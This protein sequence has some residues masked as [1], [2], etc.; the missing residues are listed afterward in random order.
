MRGR[1][2]WAIGGAHRTSSRS[3]ESPTEPR[4]NCDIADDD[5]LPTQRDK[6]NAPARSSSSPKHSPTSDQPMSPIPP[7]PTSSPPTEKPVDASRRPPLFDRVSGRASPQRSGT[8]PFPMEID[9]VEEM[10]PDGT[11]FVFVES[12]HSKARAMRAL[13]KEQ[14]SREQA[15]YWRTTTQPVN[16]VKTLFT[17]PI[18]PVLPDFDDI[19][20]PMR[21]SPV[22]GSVDEPIGGGVGVRRKT[23]VVKKLRDR[24]VK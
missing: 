19:V 15:E 16:R 6:P 3:A 22:G 21:E 5:S 20:P 13:R 14:L 7:M 2:V 24:I 12:P 8:A 1:A 17:P 18:A 9:G 4:P 10:S 11:D 23:S